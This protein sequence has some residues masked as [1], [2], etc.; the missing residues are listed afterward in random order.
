MAHAYPGGIRYFR[1]SS[2]SIVIPDFNHSRNCNKIFQSDTLRRLCAGRLS[3]SI[4]PISSKQYFQ[5]YC[6]QN[7]CPRGT[8]VS[9]Q[10]IDNAMLFS[11]D[12]FQ[13]SLFRYVNLSTVRQLTRSEDIQATLLLA[14][15][16]L[17]DRGASPDPWLLTG[18]A[19]RL[20]QRLGVHLAGPTLAA[21]ISRPNVRLFTS[22]KTYLC[23]YAFDRLYAF[24]RIFLPHSLEAESL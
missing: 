21:N 15:W 3:S 19:Y 14:C 13:S 8:M 18:S 10:G 2:T 4:F 11:S 5:N 23:L 9:D 20:A 22:W 16:G 6:F 7:H 24:F 17:N 1:L 12:D